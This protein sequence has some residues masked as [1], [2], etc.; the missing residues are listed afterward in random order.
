M[1][2][3]SRSKGMLYCVPGFPP[4]WP[5]LARN[6]KAWCFI[7]LT[8]SSLSMLYVSN[9]PTSALP[10]FSPRWTSWEHGSTT[11]EYTFFPD[12]IGMTMCSVLDSVLFSGRRGGVRE[13]GVREETNCE[14]TRQDGRAPHLSMW[15]S[16]ALLFIGAVWHLRRNK[17]VTAAGCSF[18]LT[19]PPAAIRPR[20]SL[21]SSVPGMCLDI[22]L[23][24]K[25]MAISA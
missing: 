16:C 8:V 14:D 9:S 18:L 10:L 11:M 1:D 24:I 2:L 25:G 15:G 6:T 22:N 12:N 17:H 19:I 5:Q 20:L 3:L 21:N 4:A 13:E 23:L 7:T